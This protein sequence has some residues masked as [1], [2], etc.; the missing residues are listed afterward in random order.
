MLKKL[1]ILSLVFCSFTIFA[2]PFDS[3]LTASFVAGV[4]NDKSNYHVEN[5]DGILGVD[6]AYQYHFDKNWGVELGYKG[7]SP[8]VFSLIFSDLLRNEI[9]L[10]DIDTIRLAA[11]YTAP[12]SERN[13]LILSL[14]AQR[15]D[16]NYRIRDDERQTIAKFDKDGV[17]YY[18][19]VGWRYQFDGGFLLGLSYDYQ[20]M[21]VLDLQ[22]GN[23]TIGYSF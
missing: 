2:K 16:V 4:S 18:A 21:D 19:R 6:L 7:L 14:G 10:D 9:V 5:D 11:Q 3:S 23:L 15:Y 13:Q 22:T 20:D 17:S 1:L 8:D 12:L